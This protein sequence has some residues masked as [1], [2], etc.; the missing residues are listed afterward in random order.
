MITIYNE[1]CIATMKK[2]DADS[3]PF[4]ITDPPYLL[5]FMGKEF[6][7][8]HHKFEGKNEGQKMQKWHEEWTSEVFRI[9]KPGGYLV[10]FGG[11]R[12]S[13]RLASAMEDVGFEIRDSIVW[14]Y[15]SGF[16]K[17]YNISKGIDKI[18]G[19]EREVIDQKIRGDVQKAKEKGAG[20]LAD[21]ANRN[22]I[23]QF[24]Y[25]IEDITIP[26]T[27]DAKK[28][29]GWGTA[30]KPAHEPIIIGMKPVDK[31]FVNNALEH[32]VSG[33]NINKSRIMTNSEVDDM[34]R[35]VV[36]HGRLSPV[37]RDG[38]GFKNEANNYTGV[39]EDGRWPANIILQHHP[40]CEKIGIKKVKSNSSSVPN[41]KFDSENPGIA[42]NFKT[43]IGRIGS[44]SNG[45]NDEDGN[46][47]VED[48][49]CHSD[50]PVKIINEQSGNR[51]G[52]TSPSDAKP[53]SKFRPNQNNYMPQGTIYGDNG[54]AAR[55]FYTAKSS[56]GERNLG[57][58]G[59]KKIYRLKKNV[60]NN[61]I[62]K[63]Q[64]VL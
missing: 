25:G 9:L 13:H 62:K 38:S 53:M 20:Y 4:C 63:I 2:M 33:I 32:G 40:E 39:R 27:D 7:S 8:Q 49:N 23:K 3:I 50:C 34:K 6:D 36:R 45:Y 51:P 28:W 59:V 18:A 15:G 21:P 5:N 37:W 57:L 31:N 64:K 10:A 56:K 11:S 14:I 29:D 24:G 52:C 35:E 55:F 16:P 17:S 41:P 22:N 47:I 30:L 12:T 58:D 54:G 48:W 60:S 26:A 44:D 19:V 1:N 43:G 42:Y 61:I 46:E